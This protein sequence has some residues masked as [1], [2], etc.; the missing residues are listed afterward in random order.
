AHGSATFKVKMKTDA[1]KLPIWT[2]NGGSRGGDG[3]R[4][5]GVEFD[6]YI[7]ISGAPAGTIHLPWH[8]LPHR[9]ADVSPDADAVNLK[10]G[11]ASVVL[12]N[13]DGAID[14]RVEVFPRRGRS[15]KIPRKQLPGP[16]DNFAVIDL[17]SVGAR[18]VNS[19]AG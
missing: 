13:Q 16:G 2:L 15:R 5:Q 19:G 12:K 4:L 18:L 6:G 3:F 7:N 14:G 11:P 10:Q 17:R 9:A 8:I 1:T